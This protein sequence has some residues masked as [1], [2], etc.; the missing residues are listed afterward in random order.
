MA[1]VNQI[2]RGCVIGI[3][4]YIFAFLQMPGMAV[5]H[6]G[7]GFRGMMATCGVFK[8]LQNAGLLDLI[9]YMSGLSGS[10]W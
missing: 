9:T 4:P 10:T 3:F 7:G 6:S 5:V 2:E 8:G 1:G